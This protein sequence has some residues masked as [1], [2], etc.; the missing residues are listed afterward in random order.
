MRKL[1]LLFVFLCCSGCLNLDSFM[2][3][4]EQ[5]DEYLL[6]SYTGELQFQ[7]PDSFKV[8]ESRIEIV[9]YQ[10][11]GN[12]IYG[13]LIRAENSAQ[14]TTIFY[15]YGNNN[16]I[17]YFWPRAKLLAKTGYN[18]FLFDYRGYGKSTGSPSEEG[19]YEDARNG[20]R[21]LVQQGFP[22][23]KFVYYGYSMGSAP[24]CEVAAFF[25]ESKA[26]ALVLEAPIAS[27]EMLVQ[28]GSALTFPGTYLTELQLDNANKISRVTTPFLWL[29]GRD[30]D[31]VAM[32]TH[33]ETVFRNYGG[34]RA[35]AVRVPRAV[36]KDVPKVIGFNTYVKEM[37]NF[38]QGKDAFSQF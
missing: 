33:G 17:D 12:T 10:S 15:C 16:H 30:D 34:N 31:F 36:H 25:T 5:V 28:D 9:T 24:A 29:H 11:D 32:D 21:W 35:V 8:Q 3:E 13:I 26:I 23:D 19:I 18:V 22:F 38:I 20:L 6:E 2:F 4:P 27:A 7:V 37:R 14:D 1:S